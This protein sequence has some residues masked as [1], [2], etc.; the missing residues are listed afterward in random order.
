[1]AA[2]A[3]PP[4]L[5]VDCSIAVSWY[6]VDEAT[7]F[8]DGLLSGFGDSVFYAPVLWRLEFVNAMLAAERRG[9]MAGGRLAAILAEVSALPIL[10]E[11]LNLSVAEIGRRAREHELTPYDL[12]YFELARQRGLPL[13][14]RDHA[15]VRAC[16]RAGMAVLTDADEVHEDRPAY[17]SKVRRAQAAASVLTRPRA[18]RARGPG[19]P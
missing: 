5:V 1:M 4:A 3:L 6:V 19:R 10:F 13:A 7:A 15:L 11:P 14:T 9:R 16:R 2:P 8:S 12:V 17:R 18:R